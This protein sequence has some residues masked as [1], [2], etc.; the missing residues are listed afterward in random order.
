MVVDLGTEFG[1]EVNKEGMADVHVFSGTVDC[2]PLNAKGDAMPIR[3]TKNLSA[4]FAANGAVISQRRS[5]DWNRFAAIK[6]MPQRPLPLACFYPL[7]GNTEDQSGNGNHAEPSK[8]KGLTFVN[9]LEGRAAH[10][11]SKAGSVIHLPVDARPSVMPKMTW[12][13]WVRP[14]VLESRP[15][16]ILSTDIV[17]YGRAMLIDNR[18]STQSYRHDGPRFAVF[19][20]MMGVDRGVFSPSGPEPLIN[21]WTFVAATY[22]NAVHRVILYVEDPR[23]HNGRGGLVESRTIGAEFGRSNPFISVGR[24]AASD[25]Y[26]PDWHQDAFDG[27]IDNVFVFREMLTLEQLEMIREHRSAAIIALA[28]GESLPEKGKAKRP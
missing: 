2:R 13:A 14:R 9:G 24:H 5:A 16:E 7:D 18:E 28:K 26:N 8:T 25:L 4:S 3:L 6:S 22:D 20:G 11:D 15:I 27:D 1:V 10:F 12:G 21:A 23:L 19:L 17:D